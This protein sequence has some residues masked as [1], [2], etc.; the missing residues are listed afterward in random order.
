MADQLRIIKYAPGNRSIGQAS[1]FTVQC[2][3]AA[4]PSS[5]HETEGDAKAR[6]FGSCRSSGGGIVELR[7]RN[8]QVR[9]WSVGRIYGDVRELTAV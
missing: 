5:F 4:K 2:T 1:C 7:G 3:P 8:G 9:R 6:A